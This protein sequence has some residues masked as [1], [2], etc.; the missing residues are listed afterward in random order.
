[1]CHNALRN[2]EAY[3]LKE[4]CRDVKVEPVLLPAH[5]DELQEGTEQ[6]LQLDISAVGL[7]SPFERS[8]LDIRV[9]H[10]LSPS[11][12]GTSTKSLFRQHEKE[13]KR[14]YQERV[15][16]VERGSF[17]PMVFMTTG[18]CGGEADKLHK[19]LAHLI[20]E[21]RKERYAD[22]LRFIRTKLAF[23]L[24]RSILCSLC[25]QRGKC[26]SGTVGDEVSYG[27]IQFD[28]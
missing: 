23:A 20:A 6:R 12:A 11:Y 3:L 13:K 24:L 21:K 1:M 15:L 2:T 28:D 9:T 5:T 27:L 14:K 25:G 18:G 4:C 8:F 7:W 26:T 17:T 22:T 10:P 16:N 19:R